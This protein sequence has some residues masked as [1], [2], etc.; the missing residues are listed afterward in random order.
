MVYYRRKGNRRYFKR[1]VR[2]PK[3]VVKKGKRWYVNASANLP[4]VGKSSLAIGSGV[5]R[6][7]KRAVDAVL[8]SHERPL[9]M[10]RDLT[11]DVNVNSQYPQFCSLV[12][13][14][15]GWTTTTGNRRTSDE[16]HID[17]IKLK[18]L[19]HCSDVQSSYDLYQR[20]MVIKTPDYLTTNEQFQT[21][22]FLS[23]S[24]LSLN[25]EYATSGSTINTQFIPDRRNYNFLYDNTFKL[26]PVYGVNNSLTWDLMLKLNQK[27]RFSRNAYNADRDYHNIY[28]CV[29]TH[30][31][32]Q[33]NVNI[34]VLRLESD[35][36]FKN[37]T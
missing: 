20:V 6:N 32:N 29:L 28:L 14:M 10:N 36:I 5:K 7:F 19:Y 16:I 24:N 35:V 8:D 13:Y 9:H 25:T 23:V 2:R 22:G 27:F 31:I 15:N 4:F 37:I 3:K 17:A 34:G 21:S 12:N 11:I 30:A 1:A 33:A 18:G 26:K